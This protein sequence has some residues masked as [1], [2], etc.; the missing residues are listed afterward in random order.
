MRIFGW[1][2]VVKEYTNRNIRIL[3]IFSF[4]FLVLSTAFWFKVIM[5]DTS[6]PDPR[7]KFYHF[8]VLQYKIGDVR[9]LIFIFSPLFIAIGIYSVGLFRL[10]RVRD[11]QKEELDRWAGESLIRRR[12]ADLSIRYSKKPLILIG[13]P[14]EM[15]RKY[16]NAIGLFLVLFLINFGLLFL[17]SALG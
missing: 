16:N 17:L 13:E 14:K 9:N 8:S 15:A 11:I 12:V 3:V 10:K 7:S 5:D 1:N 6:L 4:I 2:E